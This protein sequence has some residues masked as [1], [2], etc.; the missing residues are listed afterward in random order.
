[1][2]YA[3]QVIPSEISDPKKKDEGEVFSW[4][5]AIEEQLGYS[6]P[7]QFSIFPRKIEEL[8]NIVMIAAGGYSSFAVSGSLFLATH[9]L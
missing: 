7:K 4:G 9:V 3:S 8:N 6:F 2:L 1:M 5:R